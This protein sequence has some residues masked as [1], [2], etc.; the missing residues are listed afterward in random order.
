LEVSF[1][2]L[3]ALAKALAKALEGWDEAAL[4]NLVTR[5]AMI[6]VE[7]VTVFQTL[8]THIFPDRHAAGARE[9]Q[10]LYSVRFE[11][12]ELRGENVGNCRA[13]YVDLCSALER[14]CAR[15]GLISHE[16]MQWCQKA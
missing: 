13:I 9:G 11:A 3:L 7:K 15:Q 4:A 1:L 12:A 8:R 14:L 2:V 10:H 16:A 5:N 6:G